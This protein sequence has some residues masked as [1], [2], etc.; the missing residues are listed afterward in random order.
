MELEL[1]PE[2][3]MEIT[4]RSDLSLLYRVLRAVIKP[5]R[6]RL[7]RPSNRAQPAGSPRLV[8]PRKRDVVIQ[9]TM[10]EGVWM[11][12]FHPAPGKRKGEGRGNVQKAKDGNPT[13]ELVKDGVGA[14]AGT[15]RTTGHHPGVRRKHRVYYFC[16]GGFQS[17]PAPEHW[18]FLTY[19][20]QDLASHYCSRPLAGRGQHANG[21]DQDAEP[22]AEIELVLVSYPLA[23]NSPASDSLEILRKWLGKVMDA[24]SENGHTLSLMGDSSG[25]NVVL[26]LGFWA[27][28]NY[29]ELA[30]PQPQQQ[31]QKKQDAPSGAHSPAAADDDGPKETQRT[32]TNDNFPLTSLINISGPTDLTH[33]NPEIR[34]ADK[35][36]RV[37]TAQMARQVAEVWAGTAGTTSNS[38]DNDD[39][40]ANRKARKDQDQQRSSS[41]HNPEPIPLS[42]PSV[43]PLL[44][45]DT[46][47]HA[48][49]ARNVHVHGVL[50]THD[51]LAPDGLEFMRKCQRLGVSGRWLV[52]EGQMHCFPLAGG[53][54]GGRPG[55]REGT[56]GR[57]FL[58]SVL[59]RDYERENSGEIYNRKEISETLVSA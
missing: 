37:L 3:G 40:N 10:C 32:R 20:S 26:S 4:T 42:D 58:V 29:H 8:S 28:Q 19:L 53:G 24:A 23:P 21:L 52:W 50:G 55:I 25:G 30:L 54:R 9:E 15:G 6:P 31:Q 14:G 45:A 12:C 56:E 17:P 49:R 27:V 48:L 34:K 59:C 38:N 44:N 57:E 47:F 2:T 13:D 33:S 46:A 41:S 11:Y 22:G 35:F 39:G 51:V 5:L 1:E 43:S 7:V 16:G 36:D 18:R